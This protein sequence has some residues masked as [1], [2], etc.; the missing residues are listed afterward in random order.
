MP[1]YGVVGY[2]SQKF[3]DASA[4]INFNKFDVFFAVSWEAHF[5]QPNSSRKCFS[6]SALHAIHL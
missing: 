1:V 2:A 5:R 3:Y 6:F 4:V